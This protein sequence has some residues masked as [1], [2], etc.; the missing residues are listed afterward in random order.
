M[1]MA[2]PRV[3]VEYILFPIHINSQQHWIL[4]RVS[5]KDWCIYLY[6]YLKG[7][8]AYDVEVVKAYSIML[9]IFFKSLKFI[10]IELLV[11]KAI[12][13]L[14]LFLIFLF[15]KLCKDFF[16]FIFILLI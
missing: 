10:L 5:I 3:D 1:L 12:Y 7:S 8:K 2:K 16:C 14:N 6:N 15:K 9:P 4:I 11:I 13:A